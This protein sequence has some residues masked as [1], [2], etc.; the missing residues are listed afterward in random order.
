MTKLAI[1]GLVVASLLS[2]CGDLSE[3]GSTE[4]PDMKALAALAYE[5]SHSESWSVAADAL[6]RHT[7]V[8]NNAG[9]AYFAVACRRGNGVRLQAFGETYDGPRPGR[10]ALSYLATDRAGNQEVFD[11]Y[12]A[13]VL[14][15][16][17]EMGVE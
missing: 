2:G 6:C 1:A 11:A 4:T 10:M 17:R 7:Q 16:L 9:N 3:S 15:R 12:I 13:H 14:Q 8:Q 5:G